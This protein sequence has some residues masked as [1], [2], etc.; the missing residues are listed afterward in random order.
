MP[1]Q[2]WLQIILTLAAIFLVSIP[3]GRYMAR[4]VMGQST[5]LDRIF[6]PI[7]NAIYFLIGRRVASQAMTWKSYTIHMLATNLVMAIIIYLVLSFQNYLPLNQLNFSAVDPLLAFNTA[8]SFI[9]NTNWQAYGG[10]STLSN[11]SQM[12]GITFPMF[13]SA[14]TGFVVAMAWIR[15]FT[16]RNGGSD[17]GNLP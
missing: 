13:T 4:V 10:E 2:A 11:F 9:T 17:L 16:V 15:A 3:L 8:I 5:R 1:V 7:D 12:G 6:D 14:T